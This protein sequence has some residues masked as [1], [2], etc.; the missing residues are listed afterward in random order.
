MNYLEQL[1][2][3]IEE[4]KIKDDYNSMEELS[5]LL[6]ESLHGPVMD[7]T[8]NNLE[9]CQFIL[10]TNK[11]NYLLYVDMYPDFLKVDIFENVLPNDI[12]LNISTG[13]NWDIIYDFDLD[14][15]IVYELKVTFDGGEVE[16]IIESFE[17]NR[18]GDGSLYG[19]LNFV[20]EKLSLEDNCDCEDESD[21]ECPCGCSIEEDDEELLNTLE[22]FFELIFGEIIEHLEDNLEKISEELDEE[23]MSDILEEIVEV[24]EEDDHYTVSINLTRFVELMEYILD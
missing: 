2:L 22:P 20:E 5:A 18:S 12:E 11:D 17:D 8:D 14:D 3:A 4:S 23:K 16:H 19:V 1:K 6:I 13:H 21:E 7:V 9:V 10:P 24:I 15:H